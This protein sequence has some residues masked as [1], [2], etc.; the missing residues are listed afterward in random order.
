[1]N[2]C[3][4]GACSLSR[5]AQYSQHTDGPRELRRGGGPLQA[6]VGAVNGAELRGPRAAAVHGTGA[7]DPAAVRALPGAARA[8]TAKRHE[9]TGEGAGAMFPFG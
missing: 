1:M 9:Q 6:Q 4:F 8:Q 3:T 2:L 5:T 7:A